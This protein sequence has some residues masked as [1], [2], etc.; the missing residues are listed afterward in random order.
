MEIPDMKMLKM[1]CPVCDSEGPLPINNF[2]H[3]VVRP[4]IEVSISCDNCKSNIIF[5][6]MDPRFIKEYLGEVENHP[7]RSLIPLAVN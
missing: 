6:I 3:D 7:D 2:N 1:S 5:R 4:H